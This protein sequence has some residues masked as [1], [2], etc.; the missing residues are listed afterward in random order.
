MRVATGLEEAGNDEAAKQM[1]QLAAVYAK[2]LNR[3]RGVTPAGTS[4]KG[5]VSVKGVQIAPPPSA[6]TPEAAVAEA[7]RLMATGKFTKQEAVQAMKSSGWD[8]E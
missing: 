5:K 4:G 2:E 3:R 1:S 7:K 6:Q 8:V